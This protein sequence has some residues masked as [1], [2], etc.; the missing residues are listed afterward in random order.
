MSQASRCLRIPPENILQLVSRMVLVRSLLNYSS[1]LSFG[2]NRTSIQF[3][4]SLSDVPRAG[5]LTPL[6]ARCSCASYP[7][8]RCCPPGSSSSC[9][10]FLSSCQCSV[11]S[12]VSSQWCRTLCLCVGLVVMCAPCCAV[13][14][15]VL[16]SWSCLCLCRVCSL[17]AVACVS[18]MLL[19]CML[20]LSPRP[21]GHAR[22]L[23][24]QSGGMRA[25]LAPCCAMRSRWLSS[26]GLCPSSR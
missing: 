13:S 20:R 10:S 2:N 25:R 22:A 24:E 7:C 9:L 26:G 11:S 12:V 18:R 23:C 6:C 5:V 21:L 14:R 19:C 17:C 16:W 1:L 15:P 8:N 4:G 3:Q